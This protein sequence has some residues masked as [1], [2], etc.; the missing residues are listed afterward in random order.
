MRECHIFRNDP[1]VFVRFIILLVPWVFSPIERKSALALRKA[2][3]ESR[4]NK[5]GEHLIGFELLVWRFLEFDE[6]LDL[7]TDLVT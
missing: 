7:K 1:L 4:N 3:V 2:V 6:S 5:I